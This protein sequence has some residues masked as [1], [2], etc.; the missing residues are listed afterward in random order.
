MIGVSGHQRGDDPGEAVAREAHRVSHLKNGAGLLFG[1]VQQDD[2]ALQLLQL[3]L[4]LGVAI[5]HRHV[6]QKD[7]LQLPTREAVLDGAAE[8]HHQRKDRVKEKKGFEFKH[9]LHTN[10]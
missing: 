4:D 7:F 5:V 10:H 8:L 9:R 2:G 1:A 3:V 6:Q